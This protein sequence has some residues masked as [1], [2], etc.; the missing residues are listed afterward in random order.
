AADFESLHFGVGDL[1][2]LLIGP[3]IERTLDLEPGFGCR[4]GDQLDHC[5][6]ADE[7]LGAPVLCDV[8]E[9]P[10]L[11]LVPFR[12]AGRIVADL[13]RHGDLVCQLLQLDLPQPRA[14]AVG[15]PAVCRDHQ[16]THAGVARA[17]NPIEPSADRLHRELGRVVRD[18]DADPAD[19]GG[20]V[21]DAMRH[22]LAQ[23]LVLEVVHV[24]VQR[25]A[26]GPIIC[27]AV[28]ELPIS[29]FFLV[30]T[31]MTGWPADWAAI[32]CA[33]MCSNCALRSGWLAPSS[34]LRLTWREQLSSSTSS[35]PP[36]FGLPSWPQFLWAQGERLG[37]P[38]S[39]ALVSAGYPVR[40][41]DSED[42]GL[43]ISR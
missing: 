23:L 2:A 38:G 31:E 3:L 7:W 43:Q 19:V 12:C 35:L 20:R 9:Q 1:D 5:S 28:L 10:V 41:P 18:A 17:P 37:Q 4:C 42:A 24:H 21:V 39:H 15:P 13:D 27:T 40:L 22:H 29:S 26:F 32:T 30:S 8:A 14:R 25:V 34:V 11:D 33:L 16:L 6:A 36:G